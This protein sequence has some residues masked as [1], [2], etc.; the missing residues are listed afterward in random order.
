MSPSE[1]RL[2]SPS[3]SEEGGPKEAFATE[4]AIKDSY[5]LLL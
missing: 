3:V 1:N 2:A 5:K 4:A